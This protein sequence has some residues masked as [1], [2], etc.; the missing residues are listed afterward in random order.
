MRANNVHVEKAY[1]ECYK[2]TNAFLTIQCHLTF[3]KFIKLFF[4]VYWFM[5][6]LRLCLNM[7]NS[8]KQRFIDDLFI[9]HFVFL[10]IY[11]VVSFNVEASEKIIIVKF[12]C[13]YTT[14]NMN[15]IFATILILLFS[16][17]FFEHWESNV[18][19]KFL[20]KSHFHF[21]TF[22]WWKYFIEWYFCA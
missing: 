22:F 18:L 14:W 5:L 12:F 3:Q 7:T 20:Q 8:L 15:F 1:I 2:N 11:V 9:F 16:V 19:W 4:F 17:Y 10:S 21:K 13:V 6:F